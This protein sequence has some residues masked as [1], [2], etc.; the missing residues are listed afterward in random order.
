LTQF[1]YNK[2]HSISQKKR[3]KVN[4]TKGREMRTN[5]IKLGLVVG[6]STSMF[7]FTYEI[8]DGWQQLGAVSDIDDLSVFNNQCID[9]LWYYD[10]TDASNPQW[11][12]HIADGNTYDYCGETLTSLK[13]GQGFWTK[14]TGGCS[15]TVEG[16]ST[17][18]NSSMPT[19]PSLDGS[20]CSTN[21]DGTITH[22]GVTYGTVVSPYTGKTWLDRNLGASRVCTSIDDSECFG[23][24]YQWGREADGH[25]KANSATTST[26]ATDIVNVGSSFIL[27][28]IDKIYDWTTVDTHL[29][30]RQSNWSKT[31]GTSICPIG[32]RVPTA[33]EISVETIEQGVANNTNAFDNFLKLPASGIRRYDGSITYIGEEI[34]VVVTDISPN[35]Y[36]QKDYSM[37]FRAFNG[38]AFIVETQMG[39]GKSV[40]CIKD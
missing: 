29:T 21:N 30:L 12:L 13:K 15:I 14:A 24:Y 1:P 23:D 19:P 17:D 4:I 7:G 10:N 36:Q 37:M 2:T 9:Y 3:D 20:T 27:G 40:R 22:N 26:Q 25:E 38:D 8:K 32:Y 11:K 5:L 39:G 28:T 6:L 33:A 35:Y 18:C 31:D 16:D 34:N